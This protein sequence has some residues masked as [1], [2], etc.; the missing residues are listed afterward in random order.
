MN[1]F[2][3]PALHGGAGAKPTTCLSIP[4]ADQRVRGILMGL[5]M[6][7]WKSWG[8]GIKFPSPPQVTL[9]SRQQLST[10]EKF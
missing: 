9:L 4:V 6:P 3:V 5:K 7:E 8:T 1:L 2:G 10:V